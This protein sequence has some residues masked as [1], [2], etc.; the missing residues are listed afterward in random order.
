L[1]FAE[2]Q[3]AV[4]IASQ[5]QWQRYKIILRLPNISHTFFNFFLNDFSSSNKRR[6]FGKS[7]GYFAISGAFHRSRGLP[8][9]RYAAGGKNFSADF[10]VICLEV[11][12]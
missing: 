10:F 12:E 3:P 5:L 1:A 7:R 11:L 4:A 2:P 8:R 6:L 9:E